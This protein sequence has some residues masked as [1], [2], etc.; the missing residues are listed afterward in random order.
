VISAKGTTPENNHFSGMPFICQCAERWKE[1]QQCYSAPS[2]FT[3]V[4]NSSPGSNSLSSFLN[5]VLHFTDEKD[6]GLVTKTQGIRKNS[7]PAA[8]DVNSLKDHNPAGSG[9]KDLG[10]VVI[11][12]WQLLMTKRLFA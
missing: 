1:I 7:Q 8:T 11:L 12:E 10:F 2:N 4:Q 5:S 9:K 6:M 3:S